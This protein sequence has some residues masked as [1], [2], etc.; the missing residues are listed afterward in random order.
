[1]SKLEI[2]ILEDKEI[3]I[4]DES[5]LDRIEKF[6][7]EQVETTKSLEIK[8]PWDSAFLAQVK[9]IKNG[10]VKNRNTIARVF[11]HDRDFHT[12]HNRKNREVELKVLGIMEEEENRLASNIERAEFERVKEERRKLIPFRKNELEKYEA[13]ATDDDL[14][15]L[16]DEDFEKFLTI[17]REEW[18]KKEEARIERE[19]ML[20][21]DRKQAEE[22]KEQAI[23]KEREDA[24]NRLREADEKAK[25]EKEDA[26]RKADEELAEHA[27]QAKEREEKI[28]K[29]AENERLA[30]IAEQ[31]AKED[32]RIKAIEDAKRKKEE[33]EKKEKEDRE[34]AQKN[35]IF[36]KWLAENNFDSSKMEWKQNG[37]HFEIWSLPQKI[38]EI[39]I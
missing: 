24:E 35:E 19:R 4:Q 12:Q 39:R 17:K 26:K 32:A 9:K 37:N 31:K 27:R 29:D 34:K 13:T 6:L 33:A 10:Y 22:E 11:K 7:T 21:A 20:E 2:Q 23:K 28:K 36:K 14:L 16:S 1:M 15:A 18:T 3:Q 30:L 38:A 8:D 5:S 25:K